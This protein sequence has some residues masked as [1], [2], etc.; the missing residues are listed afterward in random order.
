MPRVR[1]MQGVPA[2]I[3]VLRKKDERRHPA[4]CVNAERISG[5]RFCECPLS[6]FYNNECHSA[7][8]CLYY[9][10]RNDE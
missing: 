1:N 9:E 10:K 3:E 4:K 8:N 6:P 2:Q 7:K 5:I